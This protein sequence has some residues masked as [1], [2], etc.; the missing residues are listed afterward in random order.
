MRRRQVRY[1]DAA[2]VR[3]AAGAGTEMRPSAVTQMRPLAVTEMGSP[4]RVEDAAGALVCEDGGEP[5]R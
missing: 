1:W 4:A 2:R 5:A 3:D